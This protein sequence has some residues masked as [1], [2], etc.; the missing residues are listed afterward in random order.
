MCVRIESH[1]ER[2]SALLPSPKNSEAGETHLLGR[3]HGRLHLDARHSI[4]LALIVGCSSF[5]LALERHFR[6]FRLS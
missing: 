2:V 3:L 5:A 4:V 6:S 1:E